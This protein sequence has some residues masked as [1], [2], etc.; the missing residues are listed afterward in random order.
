MFYTH[1]ENFEEGKLKYYYDTRD[2][3]ILDV[4]RIKLDFNEIPFQCC[5]NNFSLSNEEMSIVNSEIEQLKSKKVIVNTDK[6]AGDF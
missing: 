1:V 4:N 2:T 3:F 6:R 5:C